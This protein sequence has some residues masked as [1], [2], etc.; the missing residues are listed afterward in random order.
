MYNLFEG[1]NPRELKKVATTDA[2]NSCKPS[3]FE[4]VCSFF[5][6][7]V[8][9]PNFLPYTDI[10]KWV[11][12]NLNI[13][14]RTFKNSKQENMG[15]FTPEDLRTMYHLPMPQKAYDKAFLENF[16]K[17]NHDLM[18]VVKEWK[19]DQG[20]LKQDKLGCIQLHN[21]HHPTIL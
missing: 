14:N 17:E 2:V 9:R 1:E 4:V 3:Y 20:K 16:A 21:Y 12:K 11:I 6:R 18:K 7:I 8:A 10:V 19:V 5:H 15:S 13:A